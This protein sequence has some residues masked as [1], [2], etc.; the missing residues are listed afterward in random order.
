MWRAI[1]AATRTGSTRGPSAPGRPTRPRPAGEPGPQGA[2]LAAPGPPAR[3]SKPRYRIEAA[4]ELIADVPPPRNTVEL[5]GFATN[6]LG[7][8][9]LELEDATVRIGDRVL[10]DRVTW[11]LGPGDRIGIVGINGS[12]K[13]TLLR[14]ADRRTAARRGTTRAGRHGAARA[15]QPGARRPA[16]RA[17]GAGGHR[18]RREVRAAREAGADGV[19]GAGTARVPGV[20]AMDAG[21]AALRRRAAAA[22]ADRGC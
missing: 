20:P 19:I 12:G 18:G 15:A 10:L 8:T 5:L 11:R 16:R 2:G 3:T 6:R 14:A 1:S 4:E 21:G 22:A 9:V 7:R 17:A 13:T